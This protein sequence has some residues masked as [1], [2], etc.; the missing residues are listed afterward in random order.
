MSGGRQSRDTPCQ[1]HGTTLA[2]FV[3]GPENA[4]VCAAADAILRHD[5]SLGPIVLC[6]PTGVGKSHLARGL[7]ARRQE[8]EL[9]CGSGER[10]DADQG[11]RRGV[12]PTCT[13][14]GTLVVAAAEITS[15]ETI[16]PRP[17]TGSRFAPAETDLLIVEDVGD[18]RDRPIAQQ[19][20]THHID[21]VVA[22]GGL[23][24]VTIRTPPGESRELLPMLRSRLVGGLVVPIAMPGPA[25]RR[26]L[27]A[28][29]ASLLG[30]SLAEDA[31][32]ILA[33]GLEM[34]PPQLR[35]AI[36]T[37]ACVPSGRVQAID[38]AAARRYVAGQATTIDV[39]LRTVAAKTAR[40]FSL[41]LA[42][43]KSTSRHRHVVE[44]RAV[45]MYLA[46][47][48]TGLSLEQIG[49]YFGDRDHTTVLHNCRR[50]EEL[51][52][53]DP[54]TRQAVTALEE[55]LK[56]A[57]RSPTRLKRR[58]VVKPARGKPVAGLALSGI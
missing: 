7:T 20:L 39:A 46:R 21:E 26:A 49:A 35:G 54:V 32:D 55:S 42:D 23:V 50:T 13:R 44:A 9:R 53:A 16:A 31:A 52:I 33:A 2:C 24:V 3:A 4:L 34:S 28:D 14:R 6:G 8:N 58:A 41:T 15:D 38:A 45:A 43:L 47:R 5:A 29:W 17:G 56:R 36:V 19:Q 18:L 22:H 11:E 40:Y 57:A 12:S 25:A 1:P 37:L 30:V 27:L 10:R 48:L 51:Q